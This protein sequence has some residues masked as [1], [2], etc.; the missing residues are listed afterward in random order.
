MN[1]QEFQQTIKNMKPLKFFTAVTLN[2]AYE[3]GFK[4]AKGNALCNSCFLSEPE[5]PVVPQYVADFYE[6]IKDSFEWSLYSLCIDFHKR[7]LQEDLFDWFKLGVNK[8]IET[9]VKM[10]L[11]GYEVE[12]EQLYTVEI[13]NPNGDG[14]GVVYLGR[15]EYNKIELRIW[16]C[17]S[18]IE[19]SGNW[20]K[21]DNAQL[22]ESEIKGD[23]GWA[24]KFAK[25]VEE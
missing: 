19:F 3:A 23:F 16:D 4:E 2:E 20:K 25:E 22:T 17:Y 7:E 6:S 10:K 18:S 12:K 8:P 9:L 13:P 5:K 15:N 1:K 21:F 24:W 14:Y 11:Y